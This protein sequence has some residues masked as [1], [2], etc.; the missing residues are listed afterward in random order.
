MRSKGAKEDARALVDYYPYGGMPNVY[1]GGYLH[2]KEGEKILRTL[3][4]LRS[5]AERYK[6]E[7]EAAEHLLQRLEGLMSK[8]K[9]KGRAK[10][11]Q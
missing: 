6:K 3:N 10:R 7:S 9:V 1:S 4:T 11:E 8:D 2:T 5:D